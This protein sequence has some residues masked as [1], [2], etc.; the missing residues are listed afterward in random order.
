MASYRS[1]RPILA[2]P[3]LSAVS[4]RLPSKQCQYFVWL[5]TDRSRPWRMECRPLP[6]S[7][8]LSFRRSL[9]RCSSLSMFRKFPKPLSTYALPS[10]RPDAMSICRFIPADSGTTQAH[11][12][13]S[14]R[15][16]VRGA[17][18]ARTM[19]WPSHTRTVSKP[20]TSIVSDWLNQTCC[21]RNL[22]Q[23]GPAAAV[24]KAIQR[25]CTRPLLALKH[26]ACR[27]HW[28]REEEH[29]ST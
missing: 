12:E 1:E 21:K 14:T 17:R 5:N 4:P 18:P 26:A 29:C 11:R 6:F 27:A 24:L 28:A 16:S 15:L 9:L 10:C 2:P 13:T 19:A 8:P 20:R 7:T 22:K 23:Q 25:P 3:R